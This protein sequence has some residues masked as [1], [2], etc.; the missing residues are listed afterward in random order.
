MHKKYAYRV[1]KYKHT[2]TKHLVRKETDKTIV[3]VSKIY[4]H[5]SESYELK[6]YRE[7][8]QSETIKWCKT[9][10][11]AKRILE[12]IIEVKLATA[13]REVAKLKGDLVV[14]KS[15][16]DDNIDFNASV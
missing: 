13:E 2:I 15:I 16:S 5:S 11:T 6:E 12:S 14:A 9:L 4:R 1:H 7:F 3:Y 8:K 10:E